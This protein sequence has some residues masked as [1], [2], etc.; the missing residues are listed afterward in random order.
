MGSVVLALDQGTTSSRSILFDR[1][2]RLLG[3]AQREFPQ[4]FPQP[5][6]VEHDLL[7]IWHAQRDTAREV[8]R[9][10]GLR[11]QDVHAIGI[12]NQRETTGLWERAGGAPLARAIVWQC[13]RTAPRCAA[14]RAAG[15]EPLLR[16]RTGLVADAY[17]SATKLAW[18][19]DEIPGA[20]ARA[21]R[22][23]LAFGTIDTWLAYR[24]SG[25]RLHITDPSN[26]SRTL[27]YNITT[28]DWDDELLDYF[29]IP[30]AVLPRIV[31]SSAVY[32]QIDAEVLGA[33][34]PLAGLAGDQQ[35]AL[36]GQ[37]C[38]TPGT[39]KNTYGTGG[40]MLVNTGA[41]PV[42]S[43]R[44]LL[45]SM[46][47]DAAGSHTYVLEGAVFITGAAIQWLRDGLG[48]IASAAETEAMAMAVAD[49]GGVTFV[50]AFVGLGAPYW[51]AEARGALLGLT[52]GTTRNHI[53]RAALEAIAFQTTELMDT[54][55]ADGIPAPTALRVDGGATANNFLCQFQADLLGLP[56]DRPQ[57]VETTAAGAAY[58]AGLASGF[59]DTPG[60]V[61]DLRK[62]DRLFEPARSDD[63]RGVQLEAWRKAVARV[64]L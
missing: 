41:L 27:L 48:I 23:E 59:W 13:R 21:E 10:A 39:L 9:S 4:H 57:M 26:A 44:G 49:S 2:G 58:L 11:A 35:A 54:M 19:L 32:G 5:G 55:R 22:G 61:A 63:W 33:P 15:D 46:G 36:F 60:Q 12:T 51:D 34:V 8:L 42:R 6:W 56:V 29:N 45:T 31:P 24:L 28:R 40:F 52:R 25:G 53:A 7:D 64:R 50:P 43:Q 47:W 3:M 1:Q 14:I 38:H 16:E 30:R 17:F 62:V 20:R 18:L 37:G